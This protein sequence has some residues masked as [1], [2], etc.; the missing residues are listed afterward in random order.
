MVTVFHVTIEI[1]NVD[2]HIIPHMVYLKVQVKLNDSILYDKGVCALINERA[3][4]DLS[5]VAQY[6]PVLLSSFIIV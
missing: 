5:S 4:I 3:G 1:M 6:N 2:G